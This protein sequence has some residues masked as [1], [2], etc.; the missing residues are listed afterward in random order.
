MPASDERTESES[1]QERLPPWTT[2]DT[3]KGG[4]PWWKYVSNRIITLAE[5]VLTGAKLSEYHTGYRAF[6]KELLMKLP[7]DKNSNDFVFDNQILM[8]VLWL[9]YQIA[10]ISCPTYYFPEASSIN[11]SRSLK[12]GFGCLNTALRYRIAK[13]KVIKYP[14]CDFTRGSYNVASK[15]CAVME[16]S[17]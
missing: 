13:M 6:S 12:Y 2:I 1:P 9:G 7:I 10:E 11:F 5:N 3:L 15:Q 8:Q 4:M 16:N 17:R 14:I